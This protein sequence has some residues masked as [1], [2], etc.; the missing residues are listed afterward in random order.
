[1]KT[2][3]DRTFPTDHMIYKS[4]Y[5]EKVLHMVEGVEQGNIVKDFKIGNTRIKICDDYCYDKKTEAVQAILER[6]ALK[7]ESQ[8]VVQQTTLNEK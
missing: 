3:S 7:I 8:L 6:I 4:D 2:L 1:M 5:T